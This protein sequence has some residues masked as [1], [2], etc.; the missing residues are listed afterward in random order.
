MPPNP[1][2]SLKNN[3]GVTWVQLDRRQMLVA[4]ALS[5]GVLASGTAAATA[6]AT[7]A[8][9]F[10][11]PEG[12]RRVPAD[13]RSF[14]GWLRQLRLLP[15]SATVRLYD[16]RV[17]PRQ[18]VHA[19]VFDIDVGLRDLQ[20]CADAVMRLRAEWM[21][22]IGRAR[23]VAF[24]DTGSGKPMPFAR[25]AEGE[26]PRPQGRGLV[27]TRSAAADASYVSFR[28]YLD[29]VFIWAGS[30]SLEREL[31]A[32]PA[33]EVVGG[34][35]VIRGG[36]PG[37]AVIVVDVAAHPETGA[38]RVLLAQSYMPAQS[39]HVLKNFAEPLSSPWYALDDEAPL[40]TPEWVF[41]PRSLRRWRD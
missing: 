8:A 41:P 33:R 31:V 19:A 12:W 3:R 26:R 6:G 27:W 4:L 10:Q 38:R 9:R 5:R 28:K 13:D 37:H 17:K 29:S 11:P 23:D 35:V 34:D 32:V 36:F 24:N 18:D 7:I 40:A 21:F 25:W 20:Q 39:I 22:A 14:A 15:E 30:H 2:I 1:A 16:G